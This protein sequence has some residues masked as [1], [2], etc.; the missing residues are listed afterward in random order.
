MGREKK[1]D[2]QCLIS[3]VFLKILGFNSFIAYKKEKVLGNMHCIA[4]ITRG[5]EKLSALI[6]IHGVE[7]YVVRIQEVDCEC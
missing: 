1:L 7:K 4:N 6:G 3:K 2:V 5:R